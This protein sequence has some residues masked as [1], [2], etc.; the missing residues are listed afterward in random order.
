MLANL[1]VG[2]RMVVCIG[3]VN[4]AVLLS[5]TGKIVKCA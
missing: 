4:S 2:H 5:T 3:S 1:Y